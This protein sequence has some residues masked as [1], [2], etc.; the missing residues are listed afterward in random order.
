MDE[1]T[2]LKHINQAKFS[3]SNIHVNKHVQ[4]QQQLDI[5][6]DPRKHDVRAECDMFWR[7]RIPVE[8]YQQNAQNVR[9]TSLKPKHSKHTHSSHL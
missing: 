6:G 4:K 2:K 9:T 7:N 5:T 1:S 3:P 8:A